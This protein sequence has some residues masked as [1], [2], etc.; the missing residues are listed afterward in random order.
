MIHDDDLIRVDLGPRSYE[1]PIVS[2]QLADCA[3][4]F[5]RW[6]ALRDGMS[7]AFCEQ[8]PSVGAQSEKRN[9]GNPFALIVTDSNVAAT[10]AAT[11]RQSLTEKGW[12]CET[13]ILPAGETSK[14]LNILSHVYDRLIDLNADRR[15]LVIAVGGGVVGKISLPLMDPLINLICLQSYQFN[16]IGLQPMDLINTL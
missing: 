13:E 11:V 5:H 2:D 16:H 9:P 15:T 4:L 12:R 8:R 7:S 1:I 10:H 6:W 14:S 3:T